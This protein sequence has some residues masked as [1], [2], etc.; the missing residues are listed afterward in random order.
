MLK[1]ENLGDY[2]TTS[3][4]V[5]AAQLIAILSVPFIAN[6]S[7]PQVF[8][9]YSYV[10]SL[11]TVFVVI[12]SLKLDLVVFTISERLRQFLPS[13]FHLVSV[14][15]SALL[16]CLLIYFSDRIENE[17]ILTPISLMLA[18]YG[19]AAGEFLTQN[20]IRDGQFK[21][22]AIFRVARACVLPLAFFLMSVIGTVTPYIILL[23]FALSNLLPALILKQRDSFKSPPNLSLNGL[24][25]TAH[26]ASPTMKYMV[27]AHLLSRYSSNVFILVG[28]FLL[29]DHTGLAM[30]ALVAKFLLA[31]VSIFTS[32]MS[33]VVKREVFVS[34]KRGLKNY[35]KLALNMSVLG[36]IAITMVTSFANDVILLTMGDK[37]VDASAYAIALLPLFFVTLVFSPLT[38]T[39]IILQKQHIDL[40]WQMFNACFV[41]L[42]LYMGLQ[43]DMIT[44]LW[45]YSIAASLSLLASFF[46]CIYLIIKAEN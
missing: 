15:G 5:A 11:V 9:E 31:P 39:Y 35:L 45:F 1:I 46:V 10:L 27:P 29:N 26:A 7:G 8:G 37:W 4:G 3:L 36:A 19:I 12:S 25:E 42:A 40:T 17:T 6:L 13:L 28:G 44:A 21:R 23:S 41:S 24:L 14:V 43:S 2:L 18:M 16:S 33:D 20:N 22:N 34:P 30:Y 32:T 38:Y